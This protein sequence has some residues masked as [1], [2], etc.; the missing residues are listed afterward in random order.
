MRGIIAT[1]HDAVAYFVIVLSLVCDVVASHK[2]TRY[3]G[4]VTKI[5]QKITLLKYNAGV[6]IPP[7]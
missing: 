6:R 5:I 7:E 3:A 1:A 4:V 2:T